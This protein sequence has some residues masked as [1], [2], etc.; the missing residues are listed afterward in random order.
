M[1]SLAAL[2]LLYMSAPTPAAGPGDVDPM[3]ADVARHVQSTS[4]G[5]GDVRRIAARGEG[6]TLVWQAEIAPDMVGAIRPDDL[7]AVIANGICAGLAGPAFFTEGRTLRVEM[8]PPGGAFSSATADHCSVP[9]GRRFSAARFASIM[10][11]LVG[12]EVDGVTIASIRAEGDLVILVLDGGVGW[13]RGITA[14]MM[15]GVLLGNFCD[16]AAANHGFFNG[17]RRMRVDTLEG[18]REPIQGQPIASCPAR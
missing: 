14:E 9:A 7:A 2:L 10:Q 1:L 18:G 4:A 17:T 3:V 6:R 11:P 15:E 5:T 12:R 8:R 16:P 13:R